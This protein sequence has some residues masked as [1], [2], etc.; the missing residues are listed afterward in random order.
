MRQVGPGSHSFVR[1]TRKKRSD[2]STT[3]SEGNLVETVTL[4][5]TEIRWTYT[6]ANPAGGSGTPVTGGFNVKTNKKL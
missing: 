5:Y 2:A 1:S 3:D 6:P 4:S